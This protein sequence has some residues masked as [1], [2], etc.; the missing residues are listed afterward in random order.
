MTI[1]K[2]NLIWIDLE[3]TGLNPNIHK[4]IEIV[5][6]ITNI[7]LKILSIGPVIAI[8]QTSTQL[9]LMNTWNHKTHCEN[10][11]INRIKNSLYTEKLAETETIS[12]LKKWV[13]KNTSPMCGNT[14]S[15]D[16]QFLFKYMPTLEKYFHY[17]QI[18]VS[19]IKE[20]VIRWNPILYENLKKKHNH[21]ALSDLYES[22]YE[23]KYY[24]NNFL[25]L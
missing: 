19:T 8:N 23:L 20:L 13:P 4:I 10:G 18:D 15:K 22:V 25:K 2:N 11:L 1:S 6:L 21:K 14:I 9:K 24:R 17:R 3:M 5:T 7:N 16:R 12:F